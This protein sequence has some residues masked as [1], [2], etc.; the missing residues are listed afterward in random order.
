MVVRRNNKRSSVH[1]TPFLRGVIYG[2]LLAGWTYNEIAEEM[3]KPDGTQPTQQAIAG[4]AKQL[5]T[6]GGMA[7]DVRLR[8][9]QQTQ[10]QTTHHNRCA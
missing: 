5:Q 8:R 2:L 6:R 7:W 4:V 1:F 9:A 10:R 3:E